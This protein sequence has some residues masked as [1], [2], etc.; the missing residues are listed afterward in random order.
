M[1]VML[2]IVP[3]PWVDGSRLSATGTDD[4]VLSDVSVDVPSSSGLT[5]TARTL[6]RLGERI[7]SAGVPHGTMT[8][9]ISVAM[10]AAVS[11]MLQAIPAGL[12][13]DETEKRNRAAEAEASIVAQDRGGWALAPLIVTD[14]TYALWHRRLNA[15]FVAHADLGDRV[16]TAW[17][18]GDLPPELSR[19][20]LMD[21]PSHRRTGRPAS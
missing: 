18:T 5:F 12:P 2:A 11:L 6:V 15:G 20:Q 16:L 3:D 8:D 1:I 14:V 21:L 10:L 13:R 7:N 17:G 4:G 19:V 9:D